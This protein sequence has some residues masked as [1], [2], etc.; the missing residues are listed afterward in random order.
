MWLKLG[1]GAAI[2]LWWGSSKAAA[3]PARTAEVSIG[4]DWS[5]VFI[6]GNGQWNPAYVSPYDPSS[7]NT[8]APGTP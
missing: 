5:A 8:K 1:I 6:P 7:V 4:D 3:A 2:L